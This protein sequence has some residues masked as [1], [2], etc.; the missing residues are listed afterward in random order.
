MARGL[1]DDD[2]DLIRFPTY[3]TVSHIYADTKRTP[4]IDHDT[5]T[6]NK[7]FRNIIHFF[8]ILNKWNQYGDITTSITTQITTGWLK[9]PQSHDLPKLRPS[10]GLFLHHH[11]EDSDLL[12]VAARA[13]ERLDLDIQTLQFDPND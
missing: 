5:V 3:D 1:M 10:K 13:R 2:V 4:L 7:L 8:V 9:I 6:S 11:R 12:H